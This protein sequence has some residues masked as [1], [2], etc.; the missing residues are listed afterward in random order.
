MAV[1]NDETDAVLEANEAF[2]RAFN[3]KNMGLMDRVWSADDAITCIHPGWN[4]L[5]GR[6]AVLESW[7]A[8]LENPR[9]PRIVAGGA[10]ID[11]AGPDVAI[12][13]CR[14][15]VAGSPLAATN[16]FVREDGAWKLL[17][18]HSGGVS[19]AAL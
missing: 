9:Q 7:R 2:Y 4:V 8:I 14:E 11:W 18:H 10:T 16:V 19:A 5:R 3:Q 15:L 12:V 1:H 13:I 6:E 17:H